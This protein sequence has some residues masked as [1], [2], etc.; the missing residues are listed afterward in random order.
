MDKV[1]EFEF[2]VKKSV[3]AENISEAVTELNKRYPDICRNDL[4]NIQLNGRS[5]PYEYSRETRE[6]IYYMPGC[7]CG[8]TD[9]IHDPMADI[10]RSCK[11]QSDMAP[12]KWV[13]CDEQVAG[14]EE[15]PYYDDE[16]K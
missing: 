11:H 14:T 12:D 15:C 1:F 4:R 3:T 6:R 9:C 10:A 8:E 13:K 16:C 7:P 2:T 5:L